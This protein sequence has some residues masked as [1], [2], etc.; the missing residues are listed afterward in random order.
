M[1]V[2][3]VVVSIQ[4]YRFL[5][6]ALAAATWNAESRGPLLAVNPAPVRAAEPQMLSLPIG[7]P[8]A[9]RAFDQQVIR[10]GALSVVAPLYLPP[11][12][13]TGSGRQE[14]NP[15]LALLDLLTDRQLASLG[16]ARGL[17][18]GDLT[19][20]EQRTLFQKLVPSPLTYWK[21]TST[22]NGYSASGTPNTLA[23][24]QQA[25]VRLRIQRR[26]SLTVL[27][28]A[29]G[30]RMRTAKS[31]GSLP[32]GS[33][34]LTLTTQHAFAPPRSA[35][36]LAAKLP[37]RLKPSELP[38]ERPVLQKTLVLN[39]ATTVGEL[40]ARCQKATGLELHADLPYRSLAIQLWAAPGAQASAGDVLKALC[41]SLQATLRQVD[42]AYVLV[43]DLE[44]RAT[45]VARMEQAQRESARLAWEEREA[46]RERLTKRKLASFFP[47]A[48][49]DLL[50][51]NT[52]LRQRMEST[53]PTQEKIPGLG[54]L[55]SLGLRL[56][57]R[58]APSAI[59]ERV[60]VGLAGEEEQRQAGERLRAELAAKIAAQGGVPP[61]N[62]PVPPF[63][64]ELVELAAGYEPEL[65]LPDGS[66]IVLSRYSIELSSDFMPS[67]LAAL[68][69]LLS[70]ETPFVLEGKQGKASTVLAAPKTAAEATALVEL[71]ARQGFTQVWVE[72]ETDLAPLDAALAAGKKSRVAVGAALK[73]L[74]GSEPGLPRDFT[75][76]GEDGPTWLTRQG[77]SW[78]SLYRDS[79]APWLVPNDTATRARLLARF[80]ELAKRPE[81]SSLICLDTTP[82]GYA[83]EKF[84]TSS[85]GN[86][87]GY[88]PALRLAF[89]R[90][91]G[92]DP[93]DL[94]NR[95]TSGFRTAQEVNQQGALREAWNTNRRTLRREFLLDTYRQLRERLPQVPLY[96]CGTPLDWYGSWESAERLPERKSRVVSG[97]SA[98]RTGPSELAHQTS[99]IALRPVAFRPGALS[100]P[101]PQ[102]ARPVPLLP[103][104]PAALAYTIR[105]ALDDDSLQASKPPDWDGLVIDLRFVAPSQLGTIL[106]GV[107][108]N[109]TP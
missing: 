87:F 79:P 11:A 73:L 3:A 97:D 91:E 96:F 13:R 40:I 37:N 4:E 63:T 29:E 93:L 88:A 101:R 6:D 78:A 28:A 38:L 35:A 53:T 72:V 105:E 26:T 57:L 14:G 60:R 67:Q 56:S 22:G 65:L 95:F 86:E 9:V 46:R 62:A 106:A 80:T 59:Q 100:T 23:L 20:D 84:N 48:S 89:L 74:R 5:S 31:L 51:Q 47:F 32:Y 94:S 76:L 81:L 68:F 17:G 24:Q 107:R 71:A 44:G 99:T 39:G 85:E 8:E 104:G 30:A 77:T 12:E 43:P 19:S 61:Q 18:L 49:D 25:S 50:A 64:P 36:P 66:P 92:R 55:T 33:A 90:Q 82:P 16:S 102:G 103:D 109:S 108:V 2:P 69:P 10:C 34:F 98:D 45:Q 54:T 21:A 1:L 52:D 83:E 7:V 70:T 75:P 41:W 58:E 27:G 15:L 42:T